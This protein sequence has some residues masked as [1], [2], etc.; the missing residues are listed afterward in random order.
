VIDCLLGSNIY[1]CRAPSRHCCLAF[2]GLTLFGH[3]LFG[4]SSS[5]LS[6]FATQAVARQNLW[7]DGDG[8]SNLSAGGLS[9][10]AD[11]DKG[12]RA[13]PKCPAGVSIGSRIPRRGDP[14]PT[15]T[16][17]RAISGRARHWVRGIDPGTLPSQAIE[18]GIRAQRAQWSI[19]DAKRTRGVISRGETREKLVRRNSWGETRGEKLVGRNSATRFSSREF[20]IC[21]KGQETR[22]EKLK[23]SISSRKLQISEKRKNFSFFFW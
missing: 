15:E 5:G 2:F 23:T 16:T 10:F 21:A 4:R 1:S 11:L 14:F 8:E 20:Q 22:E 9:A 13:S 18:S 12:K 3:G 19:P 7:P 17:R 6:L